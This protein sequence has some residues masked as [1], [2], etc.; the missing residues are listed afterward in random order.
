MTDHE[1]I[2]A[3]IIAEF[4]GCA[5][6]AYLCPAGV[7]TIGYG[8]THGVRLE[9]ET[10]PEEARAMLLAD[11]HEFAVEIAKIVTVILSPNQMAALI[12]LTFNIGLAAFGAS[13]LLKRVN[14]G[15]HIG[16]REQFGRW[17]YA[18]GRVLPGLVRRRKTE[19]EL[20]AG[21]DR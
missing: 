9:M 8:H 1:G 3:G 17:I 7:P 19:A 6:K 21:G 15:D 13:T 5:L 20:Y 11:L 2:A 16:A 12:S 18:G 10:T 4:E 14:V